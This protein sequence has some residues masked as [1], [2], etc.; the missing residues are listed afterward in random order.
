MKICA[1]LAL[2]GAA[3]TAD[4]FAATPASPD[5]TIYIHAG[6]LLADPATGKVLSHS[7]VVISAGKVIRIEDGFTDA[8]GAKIVDLANSFDDGRGPASQIIAGNRRIVRGLLLPG[9]TPQPS[10]S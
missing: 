1:V 6:H 2:L 3:V 7:T 9:S 4:G 5:Q 10:T 8:P